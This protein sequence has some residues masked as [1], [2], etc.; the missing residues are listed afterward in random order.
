MGR[1]EDERDLRVA[2]PLAEEDCERLISSFLGQSELAPDAKA[3][4]LEAAEGNPLFVEE[5]LEMLEML[6]DDGLLERDNGSWVVTRDLGE[7]S[8]PPTIQ[9]LLAARVDRLSNEERTVAQRASVEGKVFH[10]GAVSELA[11]ESIRPT[12]SAHLLSLVR[13]ELVRP[14]EAEFAGEDAYRFRHLLIRDAAYQSLSKAD[15][16]QLHERFAVWLEGRLGADDEDYEE[17]LGYHLEQAYRCRVELGSEDDGLARRAAARL[18][19]AAKRAG[20]RGDSRGA[21]R[22]LERAD[23]LLGTQDREALEIRLEL[24]RAL[25][26]AGALVEAQAHLAETIERAAA[27]GE[28]LI[29]ARSRIISLD[30]RIRTQPKGATEEAERESERLRPV[31]ELAQDHAGLVEYWELVGMAHWMSGQAG[32]TAVA[33]ERALHH[34]RELGD[35]GEVFNRTLWLAI[36][37]AYGP[38]PA[39]VALERFEELVA[40]LA[41]NRVRAAQIRYPTISLLAMQGRFEE[42]RAAIADYQEVMEELGW[43][44]ADWSTGHQEVAGELLAGDF[45]S[46]ERYGRAAY[47]RLEE[48]GADGYLST[49]AAYLAEALLGRG[50]VD[51]ADH[52]TR[53]SE[54][55]GAPDD[56][57]NE[58]AWR[59]AR[60]KVF[61]AQGD[62]NRAEK[63]AR[64]ALEVAAGTDWIE[65]QGHAFMTL[66]EVLLQ[67]G[68]RDEAAEAV[69]EA[70]ARFERKGNIVSA[71]SARKLLR[72]LEPE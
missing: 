30:L 43:P 48:M 40:P 67:L 4:I 22:L 56:L 15:R 59:Q 11:P 33:N 31:F 1:G 72:S 17:I 16:A 5:M 8:V 46:A 10:H 3:R 53:V 62:Y 36:A 51:E 38:T 50:A 55:L 69:R 20:S 71:E 41:G 26:Q 2:E 12:L 23:A 66:A 19:S 6:I 34:A 70:L 57:S 13:K 42:A 60:A 63:L 54:Q 27:A 28:E 7:V 64:E 18:R 61:A 49:T 21:V 58:L 14:Y 24:G 52:F 65:S 44:G 47:A 25:Y 29:E 35:A 32:Q 45:E 39:S 68:R 37:D 9:A